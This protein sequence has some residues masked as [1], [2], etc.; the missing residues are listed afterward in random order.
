MG[1]QK[2]LPLKNRLHFERRS[3]CCGKN[4]V[5]DALHRSIDYMKIGVQAG[6]QGGLHA[7]IEDEILEVTSQDRDVHA[8]QVVR[9]LITC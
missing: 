6:R 7:G 1:C 9:D 2:D 8:I 4:G 5:S 3:V